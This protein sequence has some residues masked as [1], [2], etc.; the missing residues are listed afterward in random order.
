MLSYLKP[1]PIRC[2]RRAVFARFR[3]LSLSALLGAEFRRRWLAPPIP[4]AAHF[5]APR[6]AVFELHFMDAD[7]PLPCF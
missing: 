1:P 5:F 4:I 6:A 3:R 2:R 7:E